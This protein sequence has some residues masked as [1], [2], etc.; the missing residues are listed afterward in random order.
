M[1]RI[2]W[3]GAVFLVMSGAASA[4]Q[5]SSWGLSGVL[6]PS[7]K[8]PA[9]NEI[10]KLLFEADELNVGGSE[11]R[12]GFVRGRMLGGDWGVSYVRRK[13]DDGS[14]IAT[15]YGDE[16]EV[17]FHIGE[18]T[19]T[20]DVV[21]DG[22]EVHKFTPFA[23]IKRRVQ[24]GLLFGGGVGTAK[25]TL[26]T[27]IVDA[28]FQFVGGRQMISPVESLEVREA[29]ELIL[30]GNGI[31]PLGRL[32]LAVAGLVTPGLKVRASG[33]LSFPG[34]HS[35]SISAVYLFGAQ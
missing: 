5:Q 16:P 35:F 7:W 24:I 21:I 34:M 28:N 20:R 26:D 29:K 31:V 19:T 22:V 32:E 13:I 15:S 10:F 8:V 27:R 2:L 12:I 6:A 33:G 18:F 4:Q 3:T 17:G 9:D 11:F 14:T 23:T 30:P 1:R 25:G